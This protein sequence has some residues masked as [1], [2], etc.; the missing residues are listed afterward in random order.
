MEDERVAEDFQRCRLQKNYYQDQSDCVN[1]PL[2]EMYKA[3]TCANAQMHE[4]LRE[5]HCG[6]DG[7]LIYDI[8]QKPHY[9]TPGLAVRGR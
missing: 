4:E 1:A 8:E 5:S 7:T 2:H 6:M 3:K 9:S